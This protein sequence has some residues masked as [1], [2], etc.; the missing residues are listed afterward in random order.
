MS[1]VNGALWTLK[2]E[3]MFY[4]LVPL[5]VMGFR[6]YGRLRVLIILIICS[7]VYSAIMGSLASNAGSALYLELQRQL[8]GQLV[9]FL[10]GATG[11]YYFPLFA[12][13]A[14]WLFLLALA[15]F[16]LKGWLPWEILQ[17]FALG[18]A[19]IYFACIAPFAG[20]FGK[21]GDFSYGIYIVH[22]PILQLL[23]AYGLFDRQPWLMLLVASLLVLT[24]AF[25]LWHT[26]EKRF[27]RKSSH[28]VAVNKS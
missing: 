10:V 5:V 7:V 15:A 19:V 2:I 1:A 20:N 4:L 16:I 3:A 12:K 8:P 11:Y 13:N 18:I 21:Y 22:F 25:L 23:I 26:V 17:P 27:L 6:K 14:R 28:Y 24:T 9:Y